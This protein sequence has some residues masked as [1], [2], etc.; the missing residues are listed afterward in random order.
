[1]GEVCARPG[2]TRTK[3]LKIARTSHQL[4]SARGGFL[5]RALSARL[6][7][8]SSRTIGLSPHHIWISIPLCISD[9]IRFE[10]G[11]CSI[12]R[13]L[14]WWRRW[15]AQFLLTLTLAYSVANFVWYIY[16]YEL[17]RRPSITPVLSWHCLVAHFF[18]ERA[19]N[20]R[21]G[22]PF[23]VQQSSKQVRTHLL[24]SDSILLIIAQWRSSERPNHITHYFF[25]LER[26]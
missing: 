12:I 25:L 16:N 26:Q 8:I 5:T 10:R 18:G 21:K 6:S 7:L 3:L 22:V 19:T 1:M 13:Q 24:R 2:D 14:I 11:G 15:L 9:G 4:P 17:V 23:W 20:Y